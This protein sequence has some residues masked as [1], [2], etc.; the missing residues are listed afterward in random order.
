MFFVVVII[1]FLFV[2][3]LNRLR[4]Y[5]TLLVLVIA[6]FDLEGY[7]AGLKIIPVKRVLYLLLS[8]LMT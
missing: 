2:L 6:L 1:T 3:K 7:P 8:Y 4:N 5:V